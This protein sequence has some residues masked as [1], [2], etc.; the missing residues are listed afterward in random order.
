MANQR[1]YPTHNWRGL[2]IRVP[3]FGRRVLKYTIQDWL[4]WFKDWWAYFLRYALFLFPDDLYNPFV[5]F[6]IVIHFIVRVEGFDWNYAN[7]MASLQFLSCLSKREGLTS[8]LLCNVCGGIL[9]PLA[10]A[11]VVYHCIHCFEKRVIVW[12]AKDLLKAKNYYYSAK[13]GYHPVF[14]PRRWNAEYNAI[15]REYVIVLLSSSVNSSF[16]I[17]HYH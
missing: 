9:E 10:D 16:L 17:P 4:F 7:M 3:K 12:S 15:Y 5:L 8:P 2:W 1:L 13:N 6:L 14:A 11:W